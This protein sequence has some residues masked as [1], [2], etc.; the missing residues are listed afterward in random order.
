MKMKAETLGKNKRA[1]Q[2][3]WLTCF[4]KLKMIG[5]S[6]TSKKWMKFQV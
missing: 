5:K 2:Q 6:N 1:K 3:I 4:M